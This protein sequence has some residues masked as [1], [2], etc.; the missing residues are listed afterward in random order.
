MLFRRYWLG[1]LLAHEWTWTT[2]GNGDSQECHPVAIEGQPWRYEY[3][4]FQT[5][6]SGSYA[7]KLLDQAGTDYLAAFSALATINVNQSG[8]GNLYQELTFNAREFVLP[9][10]W[11]VI[12]RSTTGITT[13]TFRVLTRPISKW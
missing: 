13:G 12:D 6:D 8:S 4:H 3:E 1:E 9:P 7:A 5:G 2:D 11:L 10:V